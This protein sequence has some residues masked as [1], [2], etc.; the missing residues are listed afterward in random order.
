VNKKKFVLFIL[1]F[2]LGI[3]TPTFVSAKFKNIPGAKAI[4]RVLVYSAARIHA[5]RVVDYFEKRNKNSS[6]AVLL[7][8]ILSR[9]D[10][11]HIFRLFRCELEL[12]LVQN[13]PEIYPALIDHWQAKL[14][15]NAASDVMWYILT[16]HHLDPHHTLNKIIFLGMAIDALE[17]HEI[18]RNTESTTPQ[19]LESIRNNIISRFNK[20][21]HELK[22]NSVCVKN[23]EIRPFGMSMKTFL[24]FCLPEL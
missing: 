20:H 17:E 18:T 13:Y 24:L 23:E 2:F 1:I 9:E 5:E 11:T 15:E 21:I 12:H 10:Y 19:V 7:K 22:M 16:S 14:P 4:A 6:T 3:N 8:Q